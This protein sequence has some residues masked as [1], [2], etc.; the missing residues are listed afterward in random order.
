LASLSTPI[1]PVISYTQGGCAGTGYVSY[2]R[3]EHNAADFFLKPD[4]IDAA[5]QRIY[6]ASSGSCGTIESRSGRV[7][8]QPNA[9][10][11]PDASSRELCWVPA[12]VT[13]YILPAITPL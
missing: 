4:W 6:V 7:M 12:A 5:A 9:A 13:E 1:I 10:C 8:N 3:I 11:S 2:P